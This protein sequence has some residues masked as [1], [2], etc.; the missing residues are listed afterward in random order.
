MCLTLPWAPHLWLTAVPCGAPAWQL[1][2]RKMLSLTEHS[3]WWHVQLALAAS[4]RLYEVSDTSCLAWLGSRPS[5]KGVCL[6]AA[7]V[8]L[9]ASEEAALV[10]LW[11]G[12]ESPLTPR[13]VHQSLQV[14]WPAHHYHNEH[15]SQCNPAIADGPAAAALCYLLSRLCQLA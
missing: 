13:M 11:E 7:L 3:T 6:Q 8:Q 5:L 2:F 10:Q 1:Y 12:S 15:F 4:H 14:S 9:N